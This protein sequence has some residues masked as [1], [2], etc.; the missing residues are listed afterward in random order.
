MSYRIQPQDA[1]KQIL[2]GLLAIASLSSCG[3]SELRSFL[4]NPDTPDDTITGGPGE[5]GGIGVLVSDDAGVG[6]AAL[7][8][9]NQL[10]SSIGPNT[11][12]TLAEG[13]RLVYPNGA[14]V[15]AALQILV[16]P[17][18]VIDGT[19]FGGTNL[20][21]N[22][23]GC[24]NQVPTTCRVPAGAALIPD[25]SNIRSD[26]YEFTYRFQSVDRNERTV[27]RRFLT[28]R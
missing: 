4:V 25:G 13:T 6:Q 27:V 19:G 28:V 8:L 20:N 7:D 12:V 11:R 18:F 16:D 24:N 2:L 23:L 22:Q 26:D 5:P 3:T 10:P 14:N 17:P 9:V 21:R 15:D 1:W